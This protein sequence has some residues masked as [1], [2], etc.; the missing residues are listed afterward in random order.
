MQKQLNVETMKKAVRGVYD[1]AHPV[2]LRV[3]EF[4]D[5]NGASS[6]S[7][8]ADGIGEDRL[9]VSQSLKK[10]RD[11]DL[12]KTRRKGVFVYYMLNGDYPAGLFVCARKLYGYMTDDFSYLVD[13]CK[14]ILPRD[15]TTMTANSI[16]LFAHIDKM[17]ILECLTLFGESCVSDIVEKTGVEQ[18]KVSQYLKRMRDSGFVTARKDGRFVYYSITDG[19]HKT[20]VKC[21]R[22][23]F[24]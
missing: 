17:R 22:R 1:I 4:L 6:V 10:M 2:R 5:V 21:V 19:I 11:A 7:A 23:H 3:L 24:G 8:I 13:G 12:V 18:I 9:I 14:K 16:K 20:I 15:F